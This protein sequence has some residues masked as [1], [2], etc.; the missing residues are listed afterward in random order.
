MNFTQVC[1]V[2][3]ICLMLVILFCNL[4]C[5]IYFI[6]KSESKRSSGTNFAEEDMKE[7]ILGLFA[8]IAANF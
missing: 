7:N 2:K 1:F 5:V 8:Y 4:V 6:V 3:Y